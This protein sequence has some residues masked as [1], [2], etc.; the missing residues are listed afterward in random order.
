MAQPSQQLREQITCFWSLL[1]GIVATLFRKR[2][3]LERN[4]STAAD[5]VRIGPGDAATPVMGIIAVTFYLVAVTLL[6]CGLLYLWWPRCEW[7]AP[8]AAEKEPKPLAPAAKG[9][10]P[11]GKEKQPAGGAA[12]AR[13]SILAIDPDTGHVTGGEEVTIH[14][15]GFTKDAVVFFGGRVCTSHYDSADKLLV[16][17]PPHPAGKV[18]ITVRDGPAVTVATGY[19]Y[20][21]PGPDARTLLLM[22]LMAGAMGGALHGLFSIAVYVGE[23]QFKQSWVLWYLLLP[24]K[25]ALIALVFFLIV[26]AGFFSPQGSTSQDMLL[27]G[28]SALVGVFTPQA[29]E[30]LKKITEAVLTQQP[31]T[32]ERIRPSVDGLTMSAVTPSVGLETG[33]TTVI[34]RGTGF[35][36][37][38]EV[39]F[40]GQPAVLGPVDRTAIVVTTPSHA[41]G[42]V[43]VT[44]ELQNQDKVAKPDAFTYVGPLTLAP[45]N[46]PAGTVVTI[47]AAGMPQVQAVKFGAGAATNVT[48]IPGGGGV[49]VT[50]PAGPPPGTVVDV[51]VE[52]TAGGSVTLTRGYTY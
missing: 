5:D 48:A 12:A 11:K 29:M 10:A 16:T 8:A 39:K 44:V 41:A 47:T 13:L 18:S 26:R 36:N 27:I 35:E 6:G 37:V 24:W 25:G 3:T 28:L 20:V 33:G 14:G 45:A 19:T 15:E 32:T 2:Q 40:G 1:R 43:A 34:L 4:M 30:K 23:R 17:S 31:T 42:N 52:F 49:T 50:T 38:K 46:G 51:V 21:C 9:D 7:K 22:V